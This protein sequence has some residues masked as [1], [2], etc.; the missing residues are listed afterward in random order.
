[1]LLAYSNLFHHRQGL[2]HGVGAEISSV[3]LSDV[4]SIARAEISA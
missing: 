3:D 1:M 2:Y 4:Q